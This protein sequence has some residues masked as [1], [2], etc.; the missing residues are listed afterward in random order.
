MTVQSLGV[1]G[2]HQLE[3]R[4]LASYPRSGLLNTAVL[5]A[6]ANFVPGPRMTRRC[7]SP[8]LR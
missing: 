4:F 8:R 5:N 7:D 6:E 3:T 2:A 1:G